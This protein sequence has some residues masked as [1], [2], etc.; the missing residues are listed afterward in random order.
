MQQLGPG[1]F[2][3]LDSAGDQLGVPAA[4]AWDH[5][6]RTVRLTAGIGLLA[7]AKAIE[8]LGLHGSNE[9]RVLCL[10][11]AAAPAVAV[12]VSGDRIVVAFPESFVFLEHLSLQ[13]ALVVQGHG[14]M[15]CGRI[16]RVWTHVLVPMHPLLMA[17]LFG[18]DVAIGWMLRIALYAPSTKKPGSL[19]SSRVLLNGLASKVEPDAL[20]KV[21]AD[22]RELH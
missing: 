1:P 22:M 8:A 11:P 12:S 17:K 15:L 14:V 21:L 7:N 9:E 10:S 18:S 3:R 13:A 2:R 19:V 16:G 5:F 20:P 6:E 4:A